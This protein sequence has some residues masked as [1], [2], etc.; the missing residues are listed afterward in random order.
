MPE[1]EIISKLP[2]KEKKKFDDSDTDE[3][4]EEEIKQKIPKNLQVIWFRVE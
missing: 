4:G 3:M 1:A 2:K